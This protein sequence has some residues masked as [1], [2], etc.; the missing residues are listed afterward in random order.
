[1]EHNNIQAKQY[2]F[3]EVDK[4][5][6]VF[7]INEIWDKP[8]KVYRLFLET[9]DEVL[10]ITEGGK[11]FGLISIGD[12]YRYYRNEEKAL[13]INRKFSYVKESSDYAGAEAFFQRVKTIHEVP[14]I[15][16]DYRWG[17]VLRK[18]SY[19]I[20]LSKQSLNNT[21]TDERM[22][23][24]R[25][26]KF[27]QFN[28]IANMDVLYY[29]IRPAID[30]FSQ[31][32]QQVIKK[33]RATSDSTLGR[34]NKMSKEE[35]RYFVGNGYHKNYMECF[36]ED[37]RQLRLYQKNGVYKYGDCN[38]ETFHILNGYRKIS[39][40][41]H[42]AQCRRIWLFGLCTIFGHYVR[43]DDTV[44]YFLQN[45]LLKNG[46]NNYEVI[47]AGRQQENLGDGG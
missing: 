16:N 26:E 18:K 43:D 46:Y 10:Y 3:I 38:N 4:L 44:A 34:F 37:F 35:Q 29:D 11:L 23:S 25:K 19:E 15:D 5:Q 40:A 9:D 20:V 6:S 42:N 1:M 28:K 33:R 45:F 2:E 30:V 31:E 14:V 27:K 12:M 22:T 24:W 41:P 21:L 32:Q 36:L 17:G 39:N 47:N 13:P 8:N 7:D